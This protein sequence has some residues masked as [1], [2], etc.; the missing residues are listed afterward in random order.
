VDLDFPK[1]PRCSEHEPR[2]A[3][4]E[5]TWERVSC[6]PFLDSQSSQL[7]TRILWMPGDAWQDQNEFGDYCLLKNKKLIAQKEVL[8]SMA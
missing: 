3:A 4:E 6:M 7:L 2:Y 8:Y 5:I 1:H